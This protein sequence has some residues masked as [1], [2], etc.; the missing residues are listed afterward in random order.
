MKQ[1]NRESS[2]HSGFQDIRQTGCRQHC[3][4]HDEPPRPVDVFRH[5]WRSLH[6]LNASSRGHHSDEYNDQGYYTVFQILHF[7]LIH[8][9]TLQHHAALW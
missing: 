9:R 4:K 5:E 1:K 8:R 2:P 6:I 7:R 3:P